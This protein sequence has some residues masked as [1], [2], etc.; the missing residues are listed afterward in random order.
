MITTVNKRMCMHDVTLINLLTHCTIID[1]SQHSFKNMARNWA[2]P[3]FQISN[4]KLITIHFWCLAQ[5]NVKTKNNFQTCPLYTY[6][7]IWSNY[8]AIIV[9]II[10]IVIYYDTSFD[11][12]QKLPKTMTTAHVTIRLNSLP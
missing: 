7:K 10:T 6:R 9:I 11:V 1:N 12:S 5:L 2:E 3:G 8:T 4:N